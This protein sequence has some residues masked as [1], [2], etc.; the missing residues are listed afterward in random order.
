MFMQGKL[1]MKGNWESKKEE[2][3]ERGWVEI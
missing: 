2:K 1:M 3:K